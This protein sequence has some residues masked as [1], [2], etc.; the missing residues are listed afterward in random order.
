[1]RDAPEIPSVSHKYKSSRFRPVSWA[2]GK[3]ESLLG[4]TGCVDEDEGAKTFASRSTDL[5]NACPIAVYVSVVG[6]PPKVGSHGQITESDRNTEG[7][8]DQRS[9][10]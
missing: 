2:C 9:Y 10:A 8:C 4:G 1:M 6:D 7:K 3:E 5:I